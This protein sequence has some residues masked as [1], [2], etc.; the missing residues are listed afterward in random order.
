MI[1]HIYTLTLTYT[2]QITVYCKLPMKNQIKKLN[3]VINNN[4]K[5]MVE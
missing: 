1:T 4:T 3:F 2:H 5:N